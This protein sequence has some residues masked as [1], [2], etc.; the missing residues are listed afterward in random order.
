MGVDIGS[1]ADQ[2]LPLVFKTHIKK[3]GHTINIS[4]LMM[5][6]YNTLATAAT[7]NEAHSHTL[8]THTNEKKLMLATSACVL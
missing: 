7:V 1:L 5:R 6:Q 2:P 8:H 4:A 3:V